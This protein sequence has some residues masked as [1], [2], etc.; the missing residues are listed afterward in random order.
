MLVD[1][2][3]GWGAEA[4]V[5]GREGMVLEEVDRED[6]GRE[7][8]C[9]LGPGLGEMMFDRVGVTGERVTGGAY[10]AGA[11]AGDVYSGCVDAVC[12]CICA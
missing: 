12:A 1:V 8:A 5:E 4:E 11:D 3:R 9:M 2:F 7:V 6:E 10:D